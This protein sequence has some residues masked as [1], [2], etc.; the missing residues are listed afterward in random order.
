MGIRSALR[1]LPLR[2][3]QFIKYCCVG[4][5]GTLIDM[6]LLALLF[7]VF[8]WPILLANTASFTAAATSNYYFNKIFTYRNKDPKIA[9]QYSKFLTISLAGLL[10][11]SIIIALGVRIEVWYIYAKA[12][13]IFI[14]LIWNWL[15]GSHCALRLR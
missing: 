2:T 4:V 1:K 14:V 9:K 12:F 10:I 8:T 6:G 15:F 11:S 5:L 13:S 3:R 7:E